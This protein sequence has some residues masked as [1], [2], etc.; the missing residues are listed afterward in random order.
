M[1]GGTGGSL[2][3]VEIHNNGHS[4][5][6]I[7]WPS[8]VHFA[9]ASAQP[10][11]SG[12]QSVLFSNYA[13][14]DWYE[15]G[16]GTPSTSGDV[17]GPSSSTSGNIVTMSGTSGK[18]IQDSGKSHSTDGTLAGNSDS[19]IPTQKA[20][21]TYVDAAVAT[22]ATL[23]GDRLTTGQETFDRIG[24]VSNTIAMTSGVVKLTYFTAR[25]TETVTTL[26]TYAGAVAAGATPTICRMGLYSIDGSGNLTL[27]ASTPNDTSL[28]S[29]IN[30][31]YAKALS[32]S[33]GV[34][35]GT[36]YAFGSICVTAAT[37]PQVAGGLPNL[38]MSDVAPRISAQLTG[39]T[40]LP[41]SITSASLNR[42]AQRVYGELIP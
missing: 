40:D 11:G 29:A 9:R 34:V 16:P 36:R 26:R 31:Q 35:A 2:L 17:T 18:V 3:L 33:V 7:T 20:T 25:K 41:S 1:S 10:S 5:T 8:N 22:S 28:W 23:V 32:A 38:M 4:G 6:S 19:L 13:G 15:V 27:I 14:T 21:K 42:L 12:V 24:I 39:Q 30:T 37:V